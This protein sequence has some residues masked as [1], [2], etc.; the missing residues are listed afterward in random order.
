ML[1]RHDFIEGIR[2]LL[3]DKDNKPNWK[4]KDVN[5]IK[6]SYIESFFS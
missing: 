2:A 6:Q 1:M 5:D 4:I 3:I